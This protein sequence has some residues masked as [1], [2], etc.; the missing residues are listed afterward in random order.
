MKKNLMLLLSVIVLASCGQQPTVNPTE[1][2]TSEENSVEQPTSEEI[3]SSSDV[4]QPEP[5]ISD[6]QP[7]SPSYEVSTPYYKEKNMTHYL[8][9]DNDIYRINIKIYFFS[10][11]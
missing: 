1:Q 11:N 5:S 10:I 3:E 4:S 9:S 6:S 7:Q 2:P 8:G